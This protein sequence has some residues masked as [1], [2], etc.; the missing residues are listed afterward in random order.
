MVGPLKKAV[1][2]F[3]PAG[4]RRRR[5]LKKL[6]QASGLRNYSATSYYNTWVQQK[7]LHPELNEFSNTVLQDGP[8][9]SIIVPA[10]NTPRRYL[11]ELLYSIVSQAYPKWELILVD[12]SDK[13]AAKDLL[14]QA[15]DLDSRIRVIETPNGGISANTNVGIK[16][17]AGSYIAFVDHD[18]TIDAYA[19]YEVAKIIMATKAELIY[20]DEDKISDDGEI[21][22]DPHYKPDWSPDL[23]T[24]VNYI[25]HLTVVKKELI[26]MVGLLDPEKDGAQDYDLLL[27][28]VANDPVIQHIPKVLYHWRVAR[29]STAQDFSSKRNVTD[30]AKSALEQ[31]FERQNLKVEVRPKPE[32]PGFYD[33]QFPEAKQLSLVILPFATGAVLRLYLN[34]LLSRTLLDRVSLTIV[35]PTGAEP[36]IDIPSNIKLKTYAPDSTYLKRALKSVPDEE[37]IVI[38]QIVLPLNSQWLTDLG[39][40]LAQMHVACVSPLIV[41]DETIIEDCGLVKYA[42]GN[43]WPLFKDES[44]QRN[45]TFF[46]NPEWVRNV[47]AVSGA[48]TLLRRRP[49]LDYIV[50]HADYGG[51]VREYSLAESQAGRYNVLAANI[52]FD[53]Y[54]IRLEPQGHTPSSH[55]NPNLVYVGASLEL[56]TPEASAINILTGLQE[57]KEKNDAE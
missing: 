13:P 33:L 32:R 16:A 14:A 38:G 23:L 26:E 50:K 49:F 28:L 34:N 18:D 45:Q 5:I 52:V 7:T 24:H 27:R 35:V 56:F 22:L 44:Y 57:K 30:A 29:G 6:L 36:T 19:L 21:Y 9:I 55:F 8:L 47:D 31:Y 11:D 42:D 1:V 37:V 48:L 2:P 20:S 10:Y 43:L 53:N 54:S 4:S 40:M 51:L 15:P 41:H 17:A 39:G 46:G 12:A 3:F 25:N